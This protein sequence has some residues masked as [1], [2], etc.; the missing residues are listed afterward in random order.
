[1]LENLLIQL[2]A[3]TA[4]VRA[5][6]IDEEVFVLS[7]GFLLGSFEIVHPA[8]ASCEG[9]RA[10][11]KKGGRNNGCYFHNSVFGST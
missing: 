1:M 11:S 2:D 3:P 4:P 8:F 10:A 6:E 5:G 7:G 9:E